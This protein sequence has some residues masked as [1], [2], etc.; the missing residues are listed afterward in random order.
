[1]MLAVSWERMDSEL[2]CSQTPGAKAS[3]AQTSLRGQI[4]MPAWLAESAERANRE[5]HFK[6]QQGYSSRVFMARK[7]PDNSHTELSQT[8]C[9]MDRST[10]TCKTNK[11]IMMV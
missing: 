8:R 4:N 6:P 11:N 10:L 5:A 9:K 2:D 1:M 7:L 3:P